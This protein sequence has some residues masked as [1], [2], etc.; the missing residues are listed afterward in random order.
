MRILIVNYEFPPIGGGASYASANLALRLVARGHEV[1]VLTSRLAGQAEQEQVNGYL[2]HRVTS[3]RKGV[4]NCGL[5]GAAS[6]V[7][8]AW[9]RM[10][11]LVPERR[12][13]VVHYFFGL[14]T[15]VLALYT[16]NRWQLP[17]VL[18]LRGS[19]VPGFDPTDRTLV[20]LH[21]MLAGVNRRIWRRAA[22]VVPNSDGLAEL[23][24]SFEPGLR[25]RVIPNAILSIGE[26]LEAPE[27]SGRTLRIVC[28]SRLIERKGIDILLQ[29]VARLSDLPFEL[30][31]VGGGREQKSLEGLAASLGLQSR[32]HFHGAVPHEQ[33]FG[34]L[35]RADTF[36]LPTLSESSSMAL[37]EALGMGL[38][39]ITT[40]V[41]GNVSTIQDGVTGLLVPPGAVDDLAAAMR[42]LLT[43]HELRTSLVDAALGRT[44]ALFTW[45]ANA[46]RYEALYSVATGSIAMR[47]ALGT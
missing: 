26:L 19:D 24:R 23:A 9:R 4:Q 36:V 33:V 1:D 41:G 25:Y 47:P 29:A 6:F 13:D 43:D 10:R 31:I 21:R 30:D 38:P 34:F 20:L 18:S 46:A 12:Y 45:E 22:A 40:S 15:G 11:Q 17:Y 37:L 3:W 7:W 39:V 2:V 32:V 16:R 27:D 8:F 28:V 5:G 35:Q 42:R 44:I 14:P